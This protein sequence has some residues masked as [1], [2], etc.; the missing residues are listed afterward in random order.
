MFRFTALS[1]APAKAPKA[2]NTMLHTFMV[3]GWPAR[4]AAPG[5]VAAAS[6]APL[7]GLSVPT[8]RLEFEVYGN[9]TPLAAENFARLCSGDL[10]LPELEASQ[11]LATN[12]LGF[13][14]SLQ[15]QVHYHGSKIHKVVPNFCVQGGRIAGAP[16][17]ETLS[18]FGDHF[19]ASAECGAV[20]FDKPGLVGTSVSAPHMHH[21]EF[22]ILTAPS[23]EH[24]EGTG[25]VCFARVTKGLESLQRWHKAVRLGYNGEPVQQLQILESGM[26]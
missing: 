13:A 10:V 6:T 18:A 23:A 3:L 22:F 1:R 25:C 4:P 14:D 15:P 16:A 21:S 19:D 24:L 20:R 9:K 26:L 2:Y 8:I 11:H 17:G 7:S 5:A 12:S